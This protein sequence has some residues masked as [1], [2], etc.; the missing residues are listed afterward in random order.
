M[1]NLK[2]YMPS[3][4]KYNHHLNVVIFWLSCFH[5]KYK[6]R[7]LKT[8][9]NIQY[10]SLTAGA[11]TKLIPPE[12]LRGI[13]KSDSEFVTVSE[14]GI[15]FAA[16]DQLGKDSQAVVSLIDASNTIQ[17]QFRI[18]IVNWMA[19]LSRI[20]VVNRYANYHFM[21]YR[22]GNIYF[23]IGRNLYITK[24]S[25]LSKK[26]ISRLPV[27]TSK[28]FPLLLTKYGNF[29]IGEKKIFYSQ[30]LNNWKQVHQ[31]QMHGSRNMFNFYEDEVNHVC[32]LYVAEYSCDPNNEHRVYRGIVYPDGSQTWK[33]IL[34][35]ESIAEYEQNRE[36]LSS[37]RHIHVVAVDPYTG[38]LWI[39]TGDEDVHCRIMFSAD[40]GDTF[41]IVGRGSQEWRTLSIWFTEQYVYWNMDSH[42]PEKIHRIH[43]SKLNEI[44]PQ[45][46]SIL[47]AGKT[48]P[49]VKYLVVDSR[50]ESKFPVSRGTSYLETIARQLDKDNKVLSL[51]SWTLIEENVVAELINGAQFS[52][53]WAKNENGED[54][55]I[56][57]AAP[58]G[59]NR[60]MLGRV[61]GIKENA[62]GS[63][64][65]QE[66]LLIKPNRFDAP[67]NVN[68]FTQLEPLFQDERGFIFCKDRNTS[69]PGLYK[70]RLV[71]HDT[72][73]QSILINNKNI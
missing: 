51:Q 22:D 2:K 64:N 29:F 9:E 32:Y 70:A 54:L 25:F 40:N 28:G 23:C 27:L 39:G 11:P 55:V 38:H 42:E 47:T 15:A 26:K 4:I 46:L 69:W 24:D 71:W 37:A 68:M 73:R 57:G 3:W 34:K 56:M 50:D 72:P 12:G 43:R 41:Q 49:G 62:D 58:E 13:W 66:L 33:S 8:E 21:A 63:N 7:K 18:T 65:V 17:F 16:K 61:F 35:F 14:D 31:I 53:C 20:E 67:Y 52:Y 5:N 30:E 59:N 60:D 6:Y 19:N 10:V 36:L 44:S 1:K 45:P 48:E